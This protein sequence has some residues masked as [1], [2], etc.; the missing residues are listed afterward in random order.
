M[1][2]KVF[3]MKNNFT[4]EKNHDKKI[5]QFIKMDKAL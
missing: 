4:L 1:T 2:S 5:K 3:L